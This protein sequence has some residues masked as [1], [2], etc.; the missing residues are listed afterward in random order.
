VAVIRPFRGIRYSADRIGSL[1]DVVAPPYD[2]ISIEQRASL[3]ASSPWN[4]VA[5]DLPRSEKDGEGGEEYRTAG[6]LW[7]EWL[8]SGILQRD[9]APAIYLLE[10][11]FSASTGR[12]GVRHGFI[13]ELKLEELGA[14]TVA[15]HERTFSGPKADRLELMRSTHA[16]IS[17]IFALYRD[18]EARLETEFARVMECEPDEVVHAGDAER[19][20]WV[21][22]DANVIDVAK[23][24]LAASSLT[25]ADGHHRYETAL[26]YRNE[27]REQNALAGAESVM[28]YL[29]SMD[30]DLT[31]LPTHRLV[32]FSPALS[33]DAL[34]KGL[35]RHFELTP[36]TADDPADWLSYRLGDGT[37][38][39]YAFGMCSPDWGWTLATLRSW[40]SVSEWINPGHS[41]AWRRLD[42][43]VLHDVILGEL[44]RQAGGGDDPVDRIRYVVSAEQGCKALREGNAD[45]LF[46][47]RPTSA[48]QIADVVQSG[49]TMP[50][51]STYFYPKLLTGLVMRD[52][53]S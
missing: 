29:S 26:T 31:I 53:E 51:K 32:R 14:D 41:D 35:S 48:K 40:N 20:I 44:A 33:M 50:Q 12:P 27:C 52:L 7:R 45:L 10:E 16:N 4:I 18:P 46:M 37:G 19:R 17:Q 38:E 39:P 47:L 21:V 22:T 11:C 3:L 23:R 15:P 43:A 2:V 25:I 30:G 49:D 9:D 8:E 34:R 5:V 28:V 6:N 42:V 13:A 24:T 1:E 36:V